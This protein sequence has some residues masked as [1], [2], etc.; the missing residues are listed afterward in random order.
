[1]FDTGDAKVNEAVVVLI[2]VSGLDG[3]VELTSTVSVE[4]VLVEPL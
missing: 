3:L 1:V 4:Q 2:P